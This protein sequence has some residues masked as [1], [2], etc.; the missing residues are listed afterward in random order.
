MQFSSIF[1]VLDAVA[2]EFVGNRIG[3]RY[4]DRCMQVVYS[5]GV[6]RGL[7]HPI[8][9]IYGIIDDP[10][11]ASITRGNRREV[12]H[13]HKSEDAVCLR[14]RNASA[15]QILDDCVIIM[16]V[17]MGGKSSTDAL[18][19]LQTAFENNLTIGRT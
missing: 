2:P 17:A 5:D 7:I 15:D 3:T 11:A 8:C 1:A 18:E 16:G 6:R 13:L 10:K 19:R 4:M 14:S 9:V 12:A